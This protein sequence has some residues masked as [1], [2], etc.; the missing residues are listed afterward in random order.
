MLPI[1]TLIVVLSAGLDSRDAESPFQNRHVLV[2]GIDGV[3]PDALQRADAP[4]LQALVDNG[5]LSLQS[6]AG[7]DL[8][9]P[10]QQQTSSGPGWSSILTGVWTDKHGIRNND[11]TGDRYDLY[12]HF[13]QRLKECEPAAYLSSIVSWNP[14]DTSIVTPVDAYTDYRAKGIGSTAIARDRSVRDKA[15]AHLQTEDPDVLFLHFDQVDGA[16][17]ANGFS[18]GTASYLS[19]I[20]S[21]D[22]L[23]GDVL[24]AVDAR[25]NRQDEDWLVIVT[26]DHGGIGTSHGG[27]TPDE[28]KIFFLVSGDTTSRIASDLKPGH[29]AVPPTVFEY[30]GEPIEEAW[31]W[32]EPAFGLP[33]YPPSELKVTAGVGRD[34]VVHWSAPIDL[35][36]DQLVLKR[37]GKIIARLSLD[38]TH[39]VDVIP[40]VFLA[41]QLVYT[42]EV[43]GAMKP[44][45]P[46]RLEM[47]LPKTL[48]EELVLHWPLDGSAIDVSDVGHVGVSS[49]DLPVTTGAFG[50]EAMLF[51]NGSITT[52]LSESLTFER[53]TH[54]SFGLW[55]RSSRASEGVVIANKP[56]G[57]SDRE[58]WQLSLTEKRGL[59]WNL[60]DGVRHVTLSSPPGVLTGGV[61]HHV[62]VSVERLQYSRLYIDG[63]LVDTADLSQLGSSDGPGPL[64]LGSDSLGLATFAAGLDDVRLW[65]RKLTELEWNSLY[66]ERAAPSQWR[67]REFTFDERF[68]PNVGFW[69]SDPDGDGRTNLEEFVLGSDIRIADRTPSL[70]AGQTEGGEP[71]LIIAQRT[72]GYGAP[73]SNYQVGGVR[74]VLEMSEDLRAES[75]QSV[76]GHGEII[77]AEY[78]SDGTHRLY[79]TPTGENKCSYFR[80]RYELVTAPN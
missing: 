16:G 3:R 30:L 4:H 9:T 76:A 26:T 51:G 7:G 73:M 66:S 38:A 14:I 63:T 18:S 69:D 50:G 53:F 22:S 47:D 71:M 1:F 13:F 37:N 42:L 60:G 77:K 40:P 32:E 48:D 29:V 64:S 33:P 17:H 72:G 31:E 20:S 58:G 65:R 54:F 21:M 35:E 52:E 41:L 36:A 5:V 19:A 45:A 70:R 44:I 61:W 15:V 75:W 59:R 56:A 68:D 24:E 67:E 23:I 62:G 57:R 46:L 28:R 12:P 55:I 11:F 39:Y 27:Q 34:L 49:G 25:P 43:E 10:S 74:S 80:L 8:G 2:I 78:R 79:W 6:V